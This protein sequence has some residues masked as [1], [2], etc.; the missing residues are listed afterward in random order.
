MKITDKILSAWIDEGLKSKQMKAVDAAVQANPELRARADALRTVGAVLRETPVAVPVTAERMAADVRREIRRQTPARTA[1]VVLWVRVG[2]AASVCLVLA[3][4]WLP[5][6]IGKNTP[7]FQAEIESV[8]SEFIGAS[9]MVYTDY[10]AGWTVVWL[11]G[12]E[13][14]PGI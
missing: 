7:V 3:A 5:S 2:M 10:D 9:T 14:E 1:G 13:L 4:L 6:I 8:D 12:V 11:D